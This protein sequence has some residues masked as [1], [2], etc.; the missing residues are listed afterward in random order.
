[1]QRETEK[2]TAELLE[3]WAIWTRCGTGYESVSPMFRGR[4][5]KAGLSP[6]ITDDLAT[7]IDGILAD[8]LRR[9]PQMGQVTIDYYMMDGNVFRIAKVRN[10][11]RNKVD[12][13]AKSGTTWVD[14]V[15]TMRKERT[16][17]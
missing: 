16:A 6:D 1:M 3:Q 4:L 10:I 2:T 8:L 11:S 9:D 12:V 5:K 7:D 15:L 13:L 17:A 14:C